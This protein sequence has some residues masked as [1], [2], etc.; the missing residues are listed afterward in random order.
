M[1]TV[2]SNQI[3]P[4]TAPQCQAEYQD[5]GP[6]PFSFHPAVVNHSRLFYSVCSFLF[7]LKNL[8]ARNFSTCLLLAFILFCFVS[9]LAAWRNYK[10]PSLKWT[11]YA[12][13][14]FCDFKFVA[15]DRRKILLTDRKCSL[16]FKE[17]PALYTHE[18][19]VECLW[20]NKNGHMFLC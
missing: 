18:S 6:S 7:L 20:S 2:T 13:Y 10:I 9:L 8:W 17:P 12:L 14:K 1:Y 4:K 15:R 5:T 16:K 11:P 19:L 3:S